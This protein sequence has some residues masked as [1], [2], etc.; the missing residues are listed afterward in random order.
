MNVLQK[1]GT[2]SQNMNSGFPEGDENS[3][4]HVHTAMFK[5]DDSQETVTT[6]V[7]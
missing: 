5:T 2:D 7:F 1:T 6:E 3:S 4:S